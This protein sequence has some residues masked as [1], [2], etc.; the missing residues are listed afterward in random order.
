[1]GTWNRKTVS[2][3]DFSDRMGWTCPASG[4]RLAG[5]MLTLAQ[6]AIRHHGPI[7]SRVAPGPTAT[8]YDPLRPSISQSPLPRVHHFVAH[9]H[10]PRTHASCSAS[11]PPHAISP[12]AACQLQNSRGRRSRKAYRGVSLPNSSQAVGTRQ[13]PDR[14]RSAARSSQ[15][16]GE[17]NECNPQDLGSAPQRVLKAHSS[18]QVAHLFADPRSAPE[19]T[20]AYNAGCPVPGR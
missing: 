3:T 18:D 9:S 17:A 5:G 4:S 12:Q 10:T 16:R 1:M 20:G 6:D 11:P 2:G 7:C 14:S 15:K 8:S 13:L 19:R